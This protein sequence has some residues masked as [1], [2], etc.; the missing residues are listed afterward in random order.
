LLS[1]TK[2][3]S[4]LIIHSWHKGHRHRSPSSLKLDISYGRFIIRSNASAK[5]IGSGSCSTLSWPFSGPS[6][7]QNN[8]SSS[9]SVPTPEDFFGTVAYH[10]LLGTQYSNRSM[11]SHCRGLLGTIILTIHSW[12]LHALTWLRPVLVFCCYLFTWLLPTDYRFIQFNSFAWLVLS[13]LPTPTDSCHFLLSI[14][15]V[16]PVA[17]LPHR[18]C[19]SSRKH[20]TFRTIVVSSRGSLVHSIGLPRTILVGFIRS[21]VLSGTNRTLDSCG[22]GTPVLSRGL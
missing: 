15:S 12:D 13:V 4:H 20:S 22:S 9:Q 5:C 2:T 17:L 10:S 21:I 1:H 14:C 11:H 7:N 6:Q 19:S 8:Q 3:V 18:D 16:V